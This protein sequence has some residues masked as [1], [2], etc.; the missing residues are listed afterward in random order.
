MGIF[1]NSSLE[2]SDFRCFVSIIFLIFCAFVLVCLPRTIEPCRTDNRHLRQA[3]SW[4]EHGRLSCS[5]ATHIQFITAIYNRNGPLPNANSSAL[6]ST[7][8]SKIP[9]QRKLTQCNII[10]GLPIHR[11]SSKSIPASEMF[12]PFFLFFVLF[13]LYLCPAYTAHCRIP[14]CRIAIEPCRK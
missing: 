6:E 13:Y 8:D 1:L 12:G 11:R 10:S 7:Q 5:Y 9:L 2:T 14:D 4:L 3:L